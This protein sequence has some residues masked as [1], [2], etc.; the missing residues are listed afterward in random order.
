MQ[1][2]TLAMSIIALAIQPSFGAVAAS[3]LEGTQGGGG[4]FVPKKRV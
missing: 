3:G 2:R 4:C 1:S